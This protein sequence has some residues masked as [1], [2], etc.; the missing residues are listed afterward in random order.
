[1]LSMALS[2]TMEATAQRVRTT[3]SFDA[4]TTT[5]P[6][7]GF[8]GIGVRSGQAYLVPA[9]GNTVRLANYSLFT[10]LTSGYIPKWSGTLANSLLYDG[11]SGIGLSSTSLTG[12]SFRNSK[13]ITGA[14]TAYAQLNDGVVQSG[15]TTEANYYMT[16]A[17]TQAASFT[18]TTLNH[19]RA[20][21]GTIGAGSAVTTQ[22]GF[23]AG[24]S[25]IAAVNNYGFRGQIPSGT[26]RYNLFLD[27]TAQNHIRGN[28]GIGSGSTVP[29][30]ELEVRGQIS[31]N[32]GSLTNPSFGIVGDLNTGV[33]S[34]GADQ[35]ALVTG[36][37]SRLNVSTT[38]DVLIGSA[39]GTNSLIVSKSITGGVDAS[40][41]R[42]SGQ[43]QSDVTSNGFMFRSVANQG[44][45]ALA[46]LVGFESTVGTI[47]GT[48]TNLINFRAAAASTGYTNV[49]GFNSVIASGTNRWNL[50]INGTASNYMAGQVGIGTTSIDASALLHVSSTTQGF[51]LPRQTT[52]Q[53]NAIASPANGLMV[54]NTTLNK[55]C[56]YEN[57]SWKQ[58]STTAM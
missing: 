50:Y 27:G 33:Y 23:M 3:P 43:I 48:G 54:Y 42:S 44:A 20:F 49:Y 58:V 22:N 35:L 11:G 13:T 1:M 34:P 41:I 32:A 56:I 29:A 53:I 47:S 37:A 36:G 17:A 21:Q 30:T 8:Y 46:T 14:T 19:F 31:V 5:R 55:L 4:D 18:N 38:G 25:L 51:L 9:T 10:G 12:Y 40:G 2:T 6:R 45:H 15:V 24:A 16:T 7:T 52:T 39:A 57:G 26:N 28:T